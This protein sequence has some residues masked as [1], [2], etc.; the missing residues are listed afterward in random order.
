MG[1]FKGVK[2]A[3]KSAGNAVKKTVKKTVSNVSN[4]VEDAGLGGLNVAVHNVGKGLNTVLGG[5]LE[6][7]GAITPGQVGDGKPKDPGTPSTT[8]EEEPERGVVGAAAGGL[9]EDVANMTAEEVAEATKPREYK[10]GFSAKRGLFGPSGGFR[11]GGW[12][13]MRDKLG[14]ISKSDVA[15]GPNVSVATGSPSGAGP[16]SVSLAGGPSSPGNKPSVSLRSGPGGSRS[17]AGTRGSGILRSRGGAPG[18][19]KT[20]KTSLMDRIRRTGG[21]I[22]EAVRPGDPQDKGS[23][24]QLRNLG[25]LAR[26][27]ERGRLGQARANRQTA[28]KERQAAG[29]SP[30]LLRTAVSRTKRA[31]GDLARGASNVRIGRVA[32]G[33]GQIG[34]AGRTLLRGSAGKTKTSGRVDSKKKKSERSSRRSRRRKSRRG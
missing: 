24:R 19:D 21:N 28:A 8:E 34:D 9:H 17:L 20:G 7:I 33:A 10:K 16:P 5:G 25:S 31:A 32:R 26:G 1:L 6:K 27:G 11:G 2:N 12:D 4:A 13:K 3:V 15:G 18:G 22:A 30:S 23:G 14:G 29:E